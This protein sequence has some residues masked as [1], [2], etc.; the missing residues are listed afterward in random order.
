VVQTA[1]DPVAW[2]S[3]DRPAIPGTYWT[4]LGGVTLSLLGTQVL[5]FAMAWVAAGRGGLL[6]GLVLTMINSG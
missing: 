1:S 2:W 3:K 6:A 5:G 4:W